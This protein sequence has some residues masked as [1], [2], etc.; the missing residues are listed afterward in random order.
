MATVHVIGAGLSG[1]AAA[2]RLSREGRRV[3]VHEAAERAGGRCRSYVDEQLGVEIDNGNHL[4][5]SGNSAAMALLDETGARDAIFTAPHAAFPF[6][7]LADG[8]RWTV[9]PNTGRL[10]WWLLVPSRRVPG[11]V[12]ADY[13]AALRLRRAGPETTMSACF[14]T[15][16][17]AFRRF[18]APLTV[19]I[20][21]AQPD[22]AAAALMWPVL[23]ET[24]GRGA[25]ACRPCIA[26]R[27][28]S[29][30]FVSPT[31]DVL[32]RRG[33]ELRFSSRVRALHLASDRAAAI[34][35]TRG[36]EA[37]GDDDAVVLAV[38]PAV[39]QS[40]LPDLVAPR[41][42]RPIVNAHF[43]LPQPVPAP[44]GLPFLGIVGG[45][46]EWLFVRDRVIS[47]TVSAAAR[48]VDMPAD[49][50]AAR[51]WTDVT[52]ALDLPHAPVPPV[53]IVK[54]KRATFAQIPAEVARRP[55]AV[56]PWRNLVL[57]G[58]WTDTGLPA[59][60]EGAIRS[61]NAAAEV[62]LATR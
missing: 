19:A 3:V 56:T 49:D 31:L 61:G 55:G 23:L 60:I 26:R 11:S 37:L 53:R 40:L 57:A 32:T 59:T 58:D 50:I 24:F 38:P 30:A 21:N 45:T 2:L 16:R 17:P 15:R 22:E 54:E 28:L 29:A 7:D 9:R 39:A 8:T 14:D 52:R 35:G 12:L 46:A 34:E 42:S 43:L 44:G 36:S 48:L 18:W 41:E 51:L 27:G 5:L 62:L 1:L 6:V 47:I 13:T 4:L 33:A 25:A 10:P 20:L